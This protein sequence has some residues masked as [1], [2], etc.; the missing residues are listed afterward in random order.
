MDM[1]EANEL[2]GLKSTKFFVLEFQ[3]RT[4]FETGLMVF[5]NGGR[6][7]HVLVQMENGGIYFQV[8]CEQGEQV[9]EA[10]YPKSDVANVCDGEWHEL[11]VV[12]NVNQLVMIIDDGAE[13]YYSRAVDGSVTLQT[14]GTVT[15]GG[16]KP[17]SDSAKYIEENNLGRRTTRKFLLA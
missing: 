10:V 14:S 2:E 7:E 1:D 5:V 17:G 13:R 12:L 6:G 4:E 9:F 3:F 8:S 11:K 16:I 15:F